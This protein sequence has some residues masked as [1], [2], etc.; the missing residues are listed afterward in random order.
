MLEAGDDVEQ[1]GLA[2]ARVANHREELAFGD[3]ER[4]IAEHTRLRGNGRRREVL[5]DVV[6]D[7]EVD[8]SL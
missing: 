7:A 1:G 8:L 2:A 3:R 5:R 6:H 4:D